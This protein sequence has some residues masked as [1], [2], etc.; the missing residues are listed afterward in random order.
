M[1][2]RLFGYMPDGTEV[3]RY[4]I[5]NERMNVCV[6]DLGAALISCTIDGCDVALGYDTAEAYLSNAGNMG[7][8]IGRYAN[9][10]RNGRFTL[11]GTVYKLP[12]NRPPHC[13]HGGKAGFH[14]KLWRV[15]Q[16]T[17]QLITLEL[18]S[19]DGDQGFP[20]NLT[21]TATYSLRGTV[22]SLL[23]TA[24]SDADTVC[25]LTNHSYWNLAGHDA[26]HTALCEHIFTIPSAARCELDSDTVP[27]GRLCRVEGTVFDLRHG[28]RLGDVLNNPAL[29][30]AR[31]FDHPYVLSG[32]WE[33]A[34]AVRYGDTAME[35][36]TDAPCMQVYSGNGLP[37]VSGKRGAQYGPQV[38][39][40]LE[41]QQFPDAPNC[42]AFP[43]A[44]LYAG[45][46][47]TYRTEYR[48]I[49][50]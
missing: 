8:T 7:A 32:K 6:A 44:V 37:N 23:Y 3:R 15:K 30:P 35:V 21:V 48:F 36:W 38:G 14:Q 39:F 47:K 33:C 42:A 11:N 20:G 45:E 12:C 4:E 13:L 1:S 25:S 10:I 24:V 28:V 50:K 40:C 2:G 49:K 26:G 29:K 9:R 5:H 31:G 19:P 34:A 41:T 17:P 43:S 27:T 16:Y 22:L 46:V 18:F